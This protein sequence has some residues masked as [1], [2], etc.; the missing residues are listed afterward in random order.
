MENYIY[1]FIGTKAQAIKCSPLI[2]YLNNVENAAK[3]ETNRPGRPSRK[4]NLT[5]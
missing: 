5:K 3:R 4:P 1:F 2:N